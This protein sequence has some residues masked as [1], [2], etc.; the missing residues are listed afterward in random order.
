[1]SQLI[2]SRKADCALN[3]PPR[4]FPAPSEC[5]H[6]CLCMHVNYSQRAHEVEGASGAQRASTTSP[7]LLNPPF[8]DK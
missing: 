6:I 8:L 3:V 1:M 2:P 4:A 7:A 5:V